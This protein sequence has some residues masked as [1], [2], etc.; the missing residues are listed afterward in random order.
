MI[1]GTTI[2]SAAAGAIVQDVSKGATVS[3]ASAGFNLFLRVSH[4]CWSGA[5]VRLNPASAGK[6]IK[7][8]RARDGRPAAVVIEPLQPQFDITLRQPDGST[9]TVKIRLDSVPSIQPTSAAS[10]P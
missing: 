9:K 3:Y 6:V 7:T 1:C 4:G 10:V 2:W 5:S 8:A